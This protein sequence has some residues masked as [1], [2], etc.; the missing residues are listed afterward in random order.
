MY[1]YSHHERLDT[2]MLKSVKLLRSNEYVHSLPLIMLCCDK[3]S[4]DLIHNLLL[5]HMSPCISVML[6][7]AYNIYVVYMLKVSEWS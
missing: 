6:G 3:V 5:S 2:D 1:K 4:T 7:C